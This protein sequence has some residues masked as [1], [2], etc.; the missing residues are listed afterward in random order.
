MPTWCRRRCGCS[1]GRGPQREVGVVEPRYHDAT[2]QRRLVVTRAGA[3]PVPGWHHQL[4]VFVGRNVTAEQMRCGARLFGAELKQQWA[5]AVVEPH[6]G[7][8][9]GV[10]RRL[11]ARHQQKKDGGTRAA[12]SRVVLR[13]GGLRDRQP[14]SPG[15]AEPAALGMGGQIESPSPVGEVAHR[16]TASKSYRSSTLETMSN[17]ATPI[18]LIHGLWLSADCWLGWAD[19]YRA[20][21]HVVHAPEW[22]D[23]PGIG[24]AGAV[25]HFDAFV[26]SLPDPPILIGH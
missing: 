3:L 6:F 24:V 7:A 4:G 21:G 15:L 16:N 8:A 9:H 12:G 5:A 1:A 10:P 11:L 20:A 25:D 23:D 2:D 22:P 17:E 19:R 14:T 18:V 13:Q 26:R